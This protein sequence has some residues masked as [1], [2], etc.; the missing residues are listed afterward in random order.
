MVRDRDVDGMLVD[1]LVDTPLLTLGDGKLTE[2]DG[3]VTLAPVLGLMMLRVDRLTDAVV[4]TLVGIEIDT[5]DGP[6]EGEGEVS[7]TPVERLSVGKDNE[8]AIEDRLIEVP[9]ALSVDSDI[10]DRLGSPVFTLVI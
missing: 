4:L 1:K 5:D 6:R 9:V 8:V 7:C 10:D 2:V 3:M